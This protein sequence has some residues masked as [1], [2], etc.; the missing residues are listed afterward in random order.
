MEEK[1]WE[2]YFKDR[3]KKNELA[4]LKFHEKLVYHIANGL[5]FSVPKHIERE[6]ILQAGMIGLVKSIRAFDENKNCKFVSFAYIKIKWSLIDEARKQCGV[7]RSSLRKGS[8]SEAFI[9]DKKISETLDIKE[10]A[11]PIYQDNRFEDI[12]HFNYLIKKS[13]KNDKKLLKI[14][15]EYY[16]NGRR[17]SEIA[18]MFKRSEPWV[19][20]ELKKFKN[21]MK[22]QYGVAC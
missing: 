11:L 2:N 8:E 21:L 18:K 6:D 20:L 19:S 5:N 9:A 15:N 1:L 4:L 13:I 12:D 7:R 10:H 17:M 14:V 16:F 3:N 22:E